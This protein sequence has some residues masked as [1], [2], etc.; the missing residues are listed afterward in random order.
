MHENLWVEK[1][2]KVGI[3]LFIIIRSM[4]STHQRRRGS[5]IVFYSNYGSEFISIAQLHRAWSE[6]SVVFDDTLTT[7]ASLFHNVISC[8]RL[9][10]LEHI[11]LVY[12]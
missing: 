4:E 11:G 2:P 1:F 5:L 6:Q 8:C 3:A 7:L 10:S 12:D 9:C